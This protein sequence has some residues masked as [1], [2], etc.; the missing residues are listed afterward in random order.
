MY[1]WQVVERI[2][3]GGVIPVIRARSSAEARDLSMAIADGGVASLELTLTVPGAIHVIA[4]LAPLCRDRGMLL[5]AG[6]VLDAESARA[7]ILAGAQFLVTPGLFP[8]VIRMGHRY[9]VPVIAGCQTTTEIAEALSAGADLIK[10][11]PGN[12]LGPAFVRAVRAALPQAPCIPTG[13]VSLATIPDWIA[14]G[15]VAVGVGSE[16]TAKVSEGHGAVTAHAVRFVETVR[17]CR[18]A[19]RGNG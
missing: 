9:G 12:T 13:G 17:Q 5:G 6:T 3:A 19:S 2:V 10:C 16:L 1:R 18:E 14:A 15:C 7:C 4:E 8:E 11:F